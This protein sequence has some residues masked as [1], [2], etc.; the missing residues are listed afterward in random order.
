MCLAGMTLDKCIVLRIGTLTGCPLCRESHPLCRLKNPTVISIWL[1]V[2]FHPAT[3]SVHS[4]PADNTRKRV[5]QY[6]EKER[7]DHNAVTPVSY[8]LG[9]VWCLIVSILELCPPGS[10]CWVVDFFLKNPSKR[11]SR[12]S[13]EINKTI[14]SRQHRLI[15]QFI[16]S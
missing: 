12:Y 9:Q 11:D 14:F 6:I 10:K 2:G 15:Y 1:L 5:W 8:I 3:R 4:T 16:S 7:K 13:R